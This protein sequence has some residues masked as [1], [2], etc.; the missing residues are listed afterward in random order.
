MVYRVTYS[1]V[2]KTTAQRNKLGYTSPNQSSVIQ[3]I[4]RNQ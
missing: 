3:M 1:Q 4:E 2:F